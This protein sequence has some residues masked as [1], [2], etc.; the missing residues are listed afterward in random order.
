MTAKELASAF[1]TLYGNVSYL[2]NMKINK[3]VYF[4]YAHALQN[5]T[6]LFNDSI[7]AWQYGAVIPAVYHELKAHKDMGIVSTT[8]PTTEQALQVAK[9]LWVKYGY[10]TA[11]DIM[12]FSHREDG[13]WHAVYKG[14]PHTPI[15]NEDILSSTDGIELPKKENTRG[16]AM[17]KLIENNKTLLKM[18]ENA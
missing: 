14:V 6:V 11:S 2:T 1:I 4:A 3:L 5:G 9:E 7:E 16:Y 8:I 13:A 18:L 15:T 10:M 17:D 12:R